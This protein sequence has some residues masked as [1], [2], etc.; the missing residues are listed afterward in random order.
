MSVSK[1]DEMFKKT[2]QRKWETYQDIQI[3]SH[4]CNF[5]EGGECKA[6]LHPLDCPLDNKTY[7]KE[8]RRLHLEY[9][10]GQW[11]ELLSIVLSERKKLGLPLDGV[12]PKHLAKQDT[13]WRNPY[14]QKYP[15]GTWLDDPTYSPGNIRLI[16]S[17]IER[18]LKKM[19]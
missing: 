18:E 11:K 8:Q 12:L 9:D 17:K 19:D 4:S 10:L 3:D 1:L 15:R 7:I 13:R 5:S 6:C 14:Y 16:I 2:K